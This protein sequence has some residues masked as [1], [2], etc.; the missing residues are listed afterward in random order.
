MT[1]ASSAGWRV[2]AQR[3]SGAGMYSRVRSDAPG[4]GTRRAY[5]EGYASRTAVEH[6]TARRRSDRLRLY[7]RRRRERRGDLKGRWVCRSEPHR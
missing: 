6:R 3:C 4:L 7:C 5:A 1:P 2:T